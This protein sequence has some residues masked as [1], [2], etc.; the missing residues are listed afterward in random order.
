MTVNILKVNPQIQASSTCVTIVTLVQKSVTLT[1]G[2]FFIGTLGLSCLSTTFFKQQDQVLAQ[3]YIPTIKYRDLVIDLGNGVK[4]NAQLT[5][6][7]DGNGPF[8]AVLLIHGSGALNKNETT[9]LE[10]HND[11]PKPYWQIAQ[12]LSERGFA[13]PDMIREA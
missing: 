9:G 13:V 8:P 11:G 4:T 6:P 2:L 3:Q 7:A 1:L 12:Y 10:V 5:L